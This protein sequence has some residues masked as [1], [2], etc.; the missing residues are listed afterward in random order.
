[1]V[2]AFEIVVG[3]IALAKVLSQTVDQVLKLYKAPAEV[4]AL[5][6]SSAGQQGIHTN[7][8]GLTTLRHRSN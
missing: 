6:V 2:G 1:M 4:V 8:C 5:Q 7:G 3:T